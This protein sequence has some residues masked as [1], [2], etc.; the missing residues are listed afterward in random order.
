MHIYKI[1]ILFLSL[2]IGSFLKENFMK[3]NNLREAIFAG[4]CFWCTEY[5]FQEK[6]IVEVIAGYTGGN[7]ENPTYEE[8][9]S[10]KTGHRE[11]VLI[12]YDPNVISYENLLEIFWKSIDPTNPFGQF[13][14]L[15]EQYKTAIYYLNEEQ[16]ALAEESKKRIEKSKIFEGEIFVEILPFKNF[17][18]AEEYH[19]GYFKKCKVKFEN[20]HKGS[21]R[22]NFFNELKIKFQNFKLFPEREN[23]WK[24][25]KKPSNEELKKLLKLLEYNVTQKNYTEPPFENEYYNNK[26]KGIYI[27]IVSG[28]PIFSSEDKYD[29]GS[30][31]P[32]F[33]KPIISN[34]IIEREDNSYNMS[35]IEVRSKFANSHLGHLFYDGPPPLGKRYCINS[36]S[37]NFIKKEELSKYGYSFFEEM[38]K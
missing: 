29:S 15:G 5:A 22:E 20:Y 19:Q 33:K 3:N 18:K 10:G 28:E 25:Y 38:L 24:N 11:G 34:F 6:G 32:S 23:Y 14:D 31:W 9:C 36:S 4:G 16:K 8:V 2:F 37:L 30:G 17:F 13:Y 1:L 27:D 21:G 26:E 7:K 12:K 35:R